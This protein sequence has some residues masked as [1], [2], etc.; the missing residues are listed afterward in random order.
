MGD[1]LNFLRILYMSTIFTLFPSFSPISFHISTSFS[2]NYNSDICVY[3]YV[4]IY[5]RAH[6]HI[7]PAESI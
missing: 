6:T 3:I 2:F 1:Y 4:C 7:Y 5:M